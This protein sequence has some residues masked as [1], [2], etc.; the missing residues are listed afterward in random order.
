MVQMKVSKSLEAL[1]IWTASCKGAQVFHLKLTKYFQALRV[2]FCP[3]TRILKKILQTLHQMIHIIQ[4]CSSIRK[5]A[6][7]P[8]AVLYKSGAGVVKMDRKGLHTTCV[9]YGRFVTRTY[10][11]IFFVN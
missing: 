6:K 3:K 9:H 2:F 1:H 10:L 7:G 8:E 5:V 4:L 11:K